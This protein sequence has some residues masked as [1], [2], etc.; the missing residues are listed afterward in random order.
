M[1][2]ASIYSRLA[3]KIAK[4]G[5]HRNKNRTK[6]QPE[7]KMYFFLEVDA[8]AVDKEN[9]IKCLTSAAHEPP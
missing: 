9:T 2:E 4:F 8:G 1:S 5:W 7:Q 3:S 6:Q